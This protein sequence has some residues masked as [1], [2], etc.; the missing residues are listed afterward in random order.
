VCYVALGLRGWDRRTRRG[1]RGAAAARAWRRSTEAERQPNRGCADR[2]W[3]SLRD[4]AGT[5]AQ[6]DSEMSSARC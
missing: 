1:D 3:S 2:R 5:A 6:I 4:D